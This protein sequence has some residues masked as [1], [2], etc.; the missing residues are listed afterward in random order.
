[1]GMGLLP[2]HRPQVWWP[3]N[4]VFAADF[5]T[6]RYMRDGV[7]IPARQAFSF[8]RASQSLAQQ[9]DGRWTLFQPDEPAITTRGIQLEPALEYQP[10]NSLLLGAVP[11]VL[12]EGG[13]LPTGWHVITGGN[14][15][16]TIL[17]IGMEGDAPYIR[18]RV[19]GTSSGDYQLGFDNNIVAAAP[20]QTWSASLALRLVAN[21]ATLPTPFVRCVE[22]D[23][24]TYLA[25]SEVPIPWSTAL[26]RETLARSF[27]SPNVNRAK[28]R[29]RFTSSPEDELN[30]VFDISLPTI[31]RTSKTASPALTDNISPTRRDS[32][33]L[34][35]MLPDQEQLVSYFKN[36]TLL[37]E[38][39]GNGKIALHPEQLGD[40]IVTM[41]RSEPT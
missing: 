16:T 31:V 3:D 38:Q 8:S 17:G 35:V 10:L 32:D 19:E 20:G 40:N 28:N 36:D 2:P 1:M 27:N 39:Q 26:V 9:R 11:G 4:A 21:T 7:E 12:G 6:G 22:Q 37:Y 18:L 41:I 23:G 30:V 25:A 15:T 14:L 5:V 24:G 34:D 33:M 13:L 29:T